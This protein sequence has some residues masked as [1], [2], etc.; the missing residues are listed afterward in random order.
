V[1]G[2]LAK[3]V[4]PS[5]K[6]TNGGPKAFDAVFI[7]F[8]QNSVAYRFMSLNDYSISEYRDA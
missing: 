5:Y 6:R 3:V 8:A 1:W 2:C 4:L 7:G